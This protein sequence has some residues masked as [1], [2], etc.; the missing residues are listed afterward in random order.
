VGRPR[1]VSRRV[2]QLVP[3]GREVGLR[4]DSESHDAV[5]QGFYYQVPVGARVRHR[6]W[7]VE[8]ETLEVRIGP[9]RVVYQG[10]AVLDGELRDSDLVRR[11]EGF[12][13]LDGRQRLPQALVRRVHVRLLRVDGRN[14]R[15]GGVDLVECPHA[16]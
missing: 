14:R 5:D 1:A 11:E 15:H 13:T 9:V 6:R 12:R 7:Q 8:V 16:D 2:T 10:V 3:D 4:L